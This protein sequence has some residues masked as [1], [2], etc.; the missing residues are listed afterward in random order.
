M[1]NGQRQEVNDVNAGMRNFQG[2]LKPA[3]PR[4]LDVV[5]EFPGDETVGMITVFPS[6]IL[7][8]QVNSLTTRQPGD[9]H[10]NR[11]A[12]SQEQRAASDYGTDGPRWRP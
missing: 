11:S 9:Q 2:D 1:P 4:I 8:Q 6:V 12:A 10:R 5:N 7:Q 3:D